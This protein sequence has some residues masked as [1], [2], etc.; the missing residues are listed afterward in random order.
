MGDELIKKENIFNLIVNT[1]S[2]IRELKKRFINLNKV[3][4]IF[5]E[6][7]NKYNQEEICKILKEELN[8]IINIFTNGSFI[9]EFEVIKDVIREYDKANTIIDGNLAYKPY[10]L[11]NEIEKSI[12]DL[13]WFITTSFF[14]ED[15]QK[16][17]ETTIII[18]NQITKNLNDLEEIFLSIYKRFEKLEEVK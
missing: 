15:I 1:V 18:S 3:I 11:V 10:D 14:E 13:W 5:K 7:S 16:I 6:D 17:F 2:E 9:E 8:N 12:K 4:G